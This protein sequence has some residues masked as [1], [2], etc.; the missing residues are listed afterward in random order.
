MENNQIKSKLKWHH[1]RQLNCI[2]SERVNRFQE[3]KEI[4][5]LILSPIFT[6]RT[7]EGIWKAEFW[8]YLWDE[9]LKCDSEMEV[10]FKRDLE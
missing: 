9:D 4:T 5:H 1:P 6:R 10:T 3:T 7:W 8:N 2:M